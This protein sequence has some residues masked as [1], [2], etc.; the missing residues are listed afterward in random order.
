MFT[1]HP[2]RRPKPNGNTFFGESF[3]RKVANQTPNLI[4]EEMRGTFVRDGIAI[5]FSNDIVTRN[6]IIEVKSI[7]REVEDWYLQSSILQCAVYSAL[8]QKTNGRLV[9]ST[10]FES[11][12]NPSVSTVVNPRIDYFLRFGDNMYKVVVNNPNRIVDFILE[13]AKSC[14]DWESAKRFDAQYKQREYQVLSSCFYC[15]QVK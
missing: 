14:L 5:N 2:D 4:G 6:S 11:Q 15:I 3:Q 9:T 8:L 13:K 7:N 1:E 12:G 10:F